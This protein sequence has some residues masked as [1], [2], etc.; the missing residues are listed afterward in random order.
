MLKKRKVLQVHP[1]DNVLVALQDLE[2]GET[3]VFNGAE[4]ILKE[5][6]PAKHK[7]TTVQI[8]EGEAIMMYGVLV[9]KAKTLLEVGVRISTENIRH[10][11][12]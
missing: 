12:E 11:S 4:Y 10:A 1:N 6:I 3:I 7:F 2:K 8:P 9:A 5:D